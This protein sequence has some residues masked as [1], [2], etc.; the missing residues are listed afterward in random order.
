VGRIAHLS[1]G[2]K[3]YFLRVSGAFYFFFG[4]LI[5]LATAFTR[6]GVITGGIILSAVGFF[7]SE[8]I[9]LAASS[10]NFVGNITHSFV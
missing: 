1:L 2:K 4:N 9:F 10:F 3:Y 8:A 6:P 7:T 5:A